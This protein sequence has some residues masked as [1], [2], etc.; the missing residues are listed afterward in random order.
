MQKL[1][2]TD[3]GVIRAGL[4]K[5]A[6]IGPLSTSK[7]YG[8]IQETLFNDLRSELTGMSKN[9]TKASDALGVL[10]F[11]SDSKINSERSG[12]RYSSWI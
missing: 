7:E 4:S 6:N 8:S 12:K 5:D 10:D 3:G 11:L 1:G 9:N 2:G